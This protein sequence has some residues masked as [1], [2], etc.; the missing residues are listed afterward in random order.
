MRAMGKLAKLM[1]IF[2]TESAMSPV[3]DWAVELAARQLP[4]SCAT[5]AMQQV[6]TDPIIFSGNVFRFMS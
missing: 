3:M 1:E 2:S 4:F 5:D 6:S